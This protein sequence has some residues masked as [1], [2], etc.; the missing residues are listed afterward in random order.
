MV[1]IS[2]TFV[3][4]LRHVMSSLRSLAPIETST[5]NRTMP[6]TLI[7]GASRGLGLELAK[8]LVSQGHDVFATIRSAKSASSLPSSVHVIEGVDLSE[9]S[10]G[11]TIVRGLKG[12]KLDLVIVTA[13]VFKKEV[14]APIVLDN[15][16]PLMR[17][18]CRHLI[19]QTSTMKWKCTRL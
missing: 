17:S 4:R 2:S 18:E 12:Q 11:P 3:D 6:S 13:G 16:Y 7:V 19:T 14:R 1:I 10:A 8:A 15:G 9:E 5:Y